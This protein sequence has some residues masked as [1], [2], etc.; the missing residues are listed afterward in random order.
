M[1]TAP[2]AIMQLSTTLQSRKD[3]PGSYTFLGIVGDAA[4]SFGYH[5]SNNDLIGL[6][7]GS[8]DYSLQLTRDKTGARATPNYASAWDLGFS[9]SDMVL[10]TNRLLTAAVAKNPSLV[11]IREFCG[12]TDNVHTHPYDLSNAQDG[13]LDSWDLSHLHHVH[14][15]FYRDVCNNYNAIKSVLDTICG[16]TEVSGNGANKMPFLQQY[17]LGAKHTGAVY[18]VD[19]EPG[20]TQRWVKTPAVL[21]NIQARLKARGLPNNVRKAQHSRDYYGEVVGPDPEAS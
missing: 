5:L 19:D 8:T 3:R 2:A 18:L 14:L 12:T 1:G 13:P 15:S 11:G 17:T 9:D 21:Q 4:H 6:G 10:V 16:V 7:E 20:T